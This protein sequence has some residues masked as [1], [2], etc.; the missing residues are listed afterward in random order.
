MAEYLPA[1]PGRRQSVKRLKLWDENG[2]KSFAVDLL[3][4]QDPSVFT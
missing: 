4:V 2:A 1:G 3:K